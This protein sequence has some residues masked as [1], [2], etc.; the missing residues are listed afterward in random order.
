MISDEITLRI[1]RWGFEAE[2][3]DIS[4]NFK[5]MQQ[6]IA[7]KFNENYPAQMLERLFWAERDN[8]TYLKLLKLQDENKINAAK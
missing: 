8:P 6:K 4:P 3:K 1:L 7:A 2:E 5:A